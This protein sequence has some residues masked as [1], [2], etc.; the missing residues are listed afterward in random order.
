MKVAKLV[1]LL[2]AGKIRPPREP[3]PEVYDVWEADAAD[4]K[5]KGPAP[6]PPPKMPLPGHAESYNPPAE[7]LMTEEERQEWEEQDETERAT[8]FVPQKFDCLRR[9]P[10]YQNGILERFNRCL[11]LYLCPRALKLRMN[12][13]PKSLLP[14]LPSPKDLRPFPT[15]VSTSYDG[16]SQYIRAVAFDPTGRWVATGSADG[17]RFFECT[18][19]HMAAHLA[20]GEVRSLAWNRLVLC[21]VGDDALVLE[22]PVGPKQEVDTSGV[23]VE[24]KGWTVEPAGSKLFALGVRLRVAHVNTVTYVTWH[25]KGSY[26]SAVAPKANPTK[27]CTIHNLG[28]K[29]SLT[30]FKVKGEIQTVAFHPGKPLFFVASQRSVRVYDLQKQALVKTLVSGIKHVSSIHVHPNGEHVLVGSYDRRLVWFDLELSTFPFKTLRYHER[31]IRQVAFH[32]R[33]P[34]MASASDDGSIHV[35][36]AKV[37][38]DFSNPLIVPVK[39]LRGHVPR[40]DLGVL[41]FAWHPVHPWLVSAAADAECFLWS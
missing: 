22:P 31:A 18:T 39:R 7:Y 8:N 5:R 24:A 36:H 28:T 34:L 25:A 6:I 27:Q 30:P 40:D 13:D 37:L 2:R 38:D 33:Y 32:P 1:N 19:S 3:P 21:A 4:K 10:L 41:A 23:G 12:V 14:N 29:K 16:H 9:V 26:F 35:F 20:V 11:D 15:Q 17:V